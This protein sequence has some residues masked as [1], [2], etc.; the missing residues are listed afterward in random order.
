MPHSYLRRLMIP[1]AT[2]HAHEPKIMGDC[3]SRPGT[4]RPWPFL[5]V[6]HSLALTALLI[7]LA[8]RALYSLVAGL[9]GPYLHIDPQLMHSNAF[10]DSAMAQSP[11][12]PYRIWGTWERFD[13]MWYLHIAESGYDLPASVVFYPLYPLLIKCVTSAMGSPM[14]AAILISTVASFFLSWGLLKLVVIDFDRTVARRALAFLWA[15]PGS[16]MLLA[17]YPDSLVLALIVWS[18]Y[19]SRRHRWGPSS[20]AAFLACPV[21]AVGVLVVVPLI[22][23]AWKRRSSWLPVIAGIAG[24]M[25]FPMYLMVT[26]RISSSSAYS[27]YWNTS[28]ATPWQTFLAAAEELTSSGNLLLF[29]NV[30]AILTVSFLAVSRRQPIEYLAY[31]AAAICLVLTKRTD[32]L[33]QSTTRYA[34]MIFPAFLNLGR[35]KLDG[36]L[37]IVTGTILNLTLVL[38]FL[39]WSLI[40]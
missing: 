24:G 39:K 9:V 35:S 15:W 32:P 30:A 28:V 12:L 20:L 13:T 2:G 27:S 38:L 1:L 17:A 10:A 8:N 4:R 7:T 21:K 5:C 11:S 6:R 19:W 25:I 23:E 16:F 22:F 34:L 40:L 18:L 14:I 29:I 33:L 36:T 3:S 31:S 37:V 26:G